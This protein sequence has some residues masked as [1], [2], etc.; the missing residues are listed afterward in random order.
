MTAPGPLVP[1]RPLAAQAHALHAAAAFIEHAGIPGLYL[2]IDGDRI[3]IQVP[4]DLAGPGARTATVTL[5]AAAAGGQ[6]TATGRWVTADGD[7][8]GHP[9]RI[10]TPAGDRS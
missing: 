5:L 9:L 4:A 6:V 1:A 10:F 2:T 3:S 8:A 7:L